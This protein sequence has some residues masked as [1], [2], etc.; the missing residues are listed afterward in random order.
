[1]YLYKHNF[2]WT[3][4]LGYILFCGNYFV[5]SA[6]TNNKIINQRLPCCLQNKTTQCRKIA[7]KQAVKVVGSQAARNQKAAKGT[8]TAATLL[9]LELEKR[10]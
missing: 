5:K 10:K 7:S 6:N 2:V 1:L 9:T 4:S 8:T 3:Y